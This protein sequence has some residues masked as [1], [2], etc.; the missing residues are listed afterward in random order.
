MNYEIEGIIFRAS[1][2]ITVCASNSRRSET[3]E[4]KA[5]YTAKTL[6]LYYVITRTTNLL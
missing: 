5:N 4:A 2:E 6:E 1:E 3:Q